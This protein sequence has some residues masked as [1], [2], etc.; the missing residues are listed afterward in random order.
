MAL[1]ATLPRTSDV[2]RQYYRLVDAGK[3]DELLDLFEVNAAYDRPGYA[4]M[5]G[6]DEL[7]R[8]Y[9][10]ERA[11]DRGEHTLTDVV[12]DARQVAVAGRFV[13]VLKDGQTVTVGFA[14]LFTFSP[15]HRVTRRA[16]FFATPAV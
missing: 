11:I 3:V 13:G 7:D 8:F 5:R 4:P 10:A 14:D 9:R 15:A 12:E 2:I 16:T 6:R 1:D